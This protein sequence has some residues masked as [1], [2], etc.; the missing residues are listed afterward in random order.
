M[1]EI[2]RELFMCPLA[3]PSLFQERRIRELLSTILYIYCLWDTSYISRIRHWATTT[4]IRLSMDS[5]TGSRPVVL[6]WTAH[7]C[8]ASLNWNPSS[9]IIFLLTRLLDNH[10]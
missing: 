8:A 10:Y 3:V 7:R 2:V 6:V 1:K 5:Q 4:W 9:V